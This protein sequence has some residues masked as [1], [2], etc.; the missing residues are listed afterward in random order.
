MREVLIRFEAE[1]GFG[2]DVKHSDRFRRQSRR[3][4]PLWANPST[5]PGSGA[6]HPG[7]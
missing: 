7:L 6:S 3:I 4:I 5:F 2:M 1:G